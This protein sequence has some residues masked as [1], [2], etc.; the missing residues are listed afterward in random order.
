MT[1]EE[2]TPIAIDV[3]IAKKIAPTIAKPMG[4]YLTEVFDPPLEPG[5]PYFLLFLVETTITLEDVERLFLLPSMGRLNP[6]DLELNSEEAKI[7]ER[8]Y[9]VFGGHAA[10]LTGQRARFSS[11][12]LAF[13]K[14]GSRAAGR[15]TLLAMWLS[16]CIFGCYPT[17]FIKPFTFRLAIKLSQGMPLSLGALFLG[18]LYS[19]LDQLH[20]NELAGSPYHIV[21]S[22][23]SIVM[24]QAFAWERSRNYINV[25][26]SVSGI[27]DT[28]RV[29]SL[30]IVDGDDNKVLNFLL[31]TSPSSLPC[32]NSSGFSLVKYNPHRVSH[33]FGL[34][35]DVP[36]ISDMEY[37]VREAMRPLL[38]GSAMDYWC[39]REVDVL[40]L[41]RLREGRVTL[42]MCTYW[43]KIMSSFVNFVASQK[44]ERV[45][46]GPPRFDIPPN[47]CLV[48]NTRAVCSL[49]TR[50][51][52][53]FAEW[54]ANLDGWVVYDKN[55]P[56]E[57]SS[58]KRDKSKSL[59]IE[60]HDSPIRDTSLSLTT[61]VVETVGPPL[62]PTTGVVPFSSPDFE[63]RTYRK[64]TTA[65]RAKSV[66]SNV[67]SSPRNLPHQSSDSERTQSEDRRGDFMD[68]TMGSSNLLLLASLSSYASAAIDGIS[69]TVEKET[70]V[71]LV[72][73]EV[74][75]G[76]T[77]R[78]VA[79]DPLLP[80]EGVVGA[81]EERI[82]SK[83]TMP[84]PDLDPPR[85]KKTQGLPLLEKVLSKHLDFMSRCTYGNAMRKVMF[86]SFVAVLLDIECTLIKSFNLHKVLEWKSILNELQSM[87]FDV[88]FILDWL[89]TA[90]TSCI[91]RDSEIKLAELAAKIT[92]LEKEIA[93]KVAELS[94]LTSQ[95]DSIMLSLPTSN[96]SSST[97]PFG[98]LLD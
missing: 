1:E 25:G 46:I 43:R 59:V 45:A 47:W 84:T 66:R 76:G 89:K 33:Q 22:E 64:K 86:Q 29:I 26:K 50:Q 78:G 71:P 13:K 36:T 74:T 21:N 44:Q 61:L 12:I 87:K 34:D 10:S 19:K 88:G 23:V 48:P 58:S 77:T 67:E 73:E 53:S 18:C 40:I 49:A 90:T 81:A 68:I 11:W 14:P 75:N 54:D 85:A 16:K 42:N 6:M 51:K 63:A 30:G 80:P 15:A 72:L 39:E 28:K 91:I 5:N 98:S 60:L 96:G 82:I 37:D 57:W 52:I 69:I 24:L 31:I 41:C 95:K 17:Q 38:Y 92:D 20:Y 56:A 27:C 4:Y 2:E 9:K 83:P 70:G 3:E 55:V 35:Q 97:E 8:L 7:K 79:T 62:V 65:C 94:F 93:A 32:L